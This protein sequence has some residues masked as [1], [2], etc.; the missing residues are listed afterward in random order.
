VG[1]A[2]QQGQQ[3]Q[4]VTSTG[5]DFYEYSMMALS[6]PHRCCKCIPNGSDSVEKQHFVAENVLHQIGLLCSLYLFWF[7]WKEEAL[8]PEQSKY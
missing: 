2:F 3:R 5:E 4:W 6:T 8:L 7:P 1:G